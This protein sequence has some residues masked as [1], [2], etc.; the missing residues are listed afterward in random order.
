MSEKSSRKREKNIERMQI[1]LFIC[2]FYVFSQKLL[3][4]Q[5]VVDN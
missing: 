1:E 5:K 3:V 4:F 2:L